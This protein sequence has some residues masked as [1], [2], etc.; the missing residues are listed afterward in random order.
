MQ[1]NNNYSSPNFGMALKIKPEAMQALKKAPIETLET[2]EKIGDNLK[3]TKFYHL[4]IGEQASP[5]ITSPY[6]NKYSDVFEVEKPK[7]LYPE[8]LPFKSI[9]DGT[10]I[11]G[12]KKGDPFE[13]V[14][15]YSSEKAAL[16]AYNKINSANSKLEKAALLTR[17]LDN[18]E[19]ENDIARQ[20]QIELEKAQEEKAKNLFNKFGVDDEE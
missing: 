17:E 6:A 1:I 13:G 4:E 10:E 16:E 20:A 18:K 15:K 14:I 19:I 12:M 5:R 7:E 9:W 3:D 2:L 8:F 11:S